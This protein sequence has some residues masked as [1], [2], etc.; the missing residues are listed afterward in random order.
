VLQLVYKE[1]FYIYGKISE[2]TKQLKELSK[3]FTTVKEFL[4][5]M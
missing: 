3:N 4:G 1:K 2:V 5:H